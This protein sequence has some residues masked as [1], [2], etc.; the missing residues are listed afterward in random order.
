[1]SP[2]PAPRRG[3]RLL[4]SCVNYAPEIL[5]T[6][7]Y[8]RDLAE[9]FAGRGWEVRIVTTYPY[10]P[11]WRRRPQD[12]RLAYRV[13]RGGGSGSSGGGVTVLRC[14]AWVPRV[15][16]GGRRLVHYATFAASSLPVVLAHAAWKPDFVLVVAPTL[17]SAP[18]ALL[19]ARLFGGRSW[20]HVQDYEVDV[21]L[22]LGL[23]PPAGRTAL[24]WVES[25]LLRAFDVVTSITEPMLGVARELGVPEERLVLLPNWANL[26]LVRPLG[27]P[28]RLRAALGISDERCVV[29]YSGNLGR[30]QGV[31]LLGNAARRS[32]EGGS[33]VLYVVS[34]DG[35]D[36]E[37]LASAAEDHGLTN[38]VMVPLQPDE[39]FNEL[40]NLA[41]AHLIVQEA[42][43]ADLVMP[44]KLTNMLASGRPVIATAAAGTALADL[45]REQDVG[46]VVE[47]GDPDALAEAVAALM[48]DDDRRGRQGANARA[49]AEEFLDRDRLLTAALERLQERCC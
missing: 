18:A 13:E 23:L 10:Y 7:P 15:P 49:F 43:V 11:E 32:Q 42:G 4:V 2:P 34:G 27:R 36:R 26:S 28:S 8:T 5:G 6:A 33:R 39:S 3:R 25:R 14:P 35:A 12:P 44:S 46:T 31:A 38:L 22:R 16:T 1:M 29:L 21:A 45:V 30:K 17:A 20:V 9:W 47:P 48:D 41:D 37:A 19:A 24:K 40:L